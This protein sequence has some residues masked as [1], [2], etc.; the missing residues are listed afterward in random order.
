MTVTS[1]TVCS[2]RRAES[3]TSLYGKRL[4]VGVA[5]DDAGAGLLDE[6]GRRKAA[7]NNQ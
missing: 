6:P 4:P 2:T 3:S 1:F 5:D 7:A